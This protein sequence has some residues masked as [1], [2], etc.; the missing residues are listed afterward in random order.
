MLHDDHSFKGSQEAREFLVLSR[1]ES[2]TAAA[3]E[4]AFHRWG[5]S[6]EQGVL[7]NEGWVML[8]DGR[9]M[10]PTQASDV[11]LATKPFLPE[12]P[13]ERDGEPSFRLATGIVRGLWLDHTKNERNY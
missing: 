7:R 10:W 6:T 12:S 9:L 5:S 13:I 8:C 1:V 3:S 11:I 4:V 2:T